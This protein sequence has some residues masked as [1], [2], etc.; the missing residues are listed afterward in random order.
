MPSYF[1]P[2]GDKAQPTAW[3]SIE[4]ARALNQHCYPHTGDSGH[5]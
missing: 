3:D 4:V 2:I 1:T 5:G